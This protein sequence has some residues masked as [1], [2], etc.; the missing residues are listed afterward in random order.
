[1]RNYEFR[2][3]DI[4]LGGLRRPI[5]HSQIVIPQLKLELWG[6]HRAE[7]KERITH[8]PLIPSIFGALGPRFDSPAASESLCKAAAL[9]VLLPHG[10]IERCFSAKLEPWGHRFSRK[11]TLSDNPQQSC[12]FGCLVAFGLVEVKTGFQLSDFSS[13]PQM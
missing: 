3:L 11:G 1:M 5:I 7:P 9:G 8:H 12:D 2:T 6:S 4:S 10:A 13:R